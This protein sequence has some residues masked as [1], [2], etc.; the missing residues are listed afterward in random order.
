MSIIESGGDRDSNAL[1]TVVIPTLQAPSLDALLRALVAQEPAQLIH[2]ILVVGQ[3]DDMQ[4]LTQLPKVRYIHVEDRP[5][6][7]RNRNTGAVQAGTEW[8]C[9]LDTDTIP[10][11]GWLAG[12]RT[13]MATGASVVAGAVAIPDDAGYWARCDNLLAFGTQLS[14]HDGP[15]T[16]ESAA[17]INFA[18]KRTIF[19]DLNGFDE[20]FS[21]AAGEDRDLCWRLRQAGFQI[22]FVPGAVVTHHHARLDRRSAF[23]HFYLYGQATTQFRLLRSDSQRWQVGARLVRIPLLGEAAG[24]VRVAVRAFLRP[25]R[26]RNYLTDNLDALPGVMLLDWAHTLGMIHALRQASQRAVNLVD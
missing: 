21:S 14:Q 5:S 22:V 3:Q 9:F 20:S 2:E 4:R 18:I 12:L 6:P 11:V 26:Q 1:V 25:I 13:A 16:L 17:T 7:A 10:E 8:V 24:L 19:C 23:Q 15:L